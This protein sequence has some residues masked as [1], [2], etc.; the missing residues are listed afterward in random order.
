MV[1]AF[2]FMKKKSKKRTKRSFSYSPPSTDLKKLKLAATSTGKE[3]EV[4]KEHSDPL[5]GV[6]K[7][8]VDSIQSLG[9]RLENKIEQLQTDM[10]C[11]HLEI[12]ENLA[13]LKATISDIEKSLEQAWEYIEDHTADLKAHKDVKDS[14][15]KEI[16]KLKSELQ[17][18][19]LLL[20][21]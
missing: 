13:G 1:N 7:Q 15:Q 3:H 21:V 14:Q 11:F 20:N 16:D 4:G 9:D 8:I 5:D 2:P 12:K 17:K 18:T 10:D 19:L 6:L